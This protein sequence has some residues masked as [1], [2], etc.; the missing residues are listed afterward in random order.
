MCGAVTGR[1]DSGSCPYGGAT[2]PVRPR[3]GQC[4]L[5]GRRDRRT[6]FVV[7]R[8]G[9]PYV[10]G[11]CSERDAANVTLS[12]TCPYGRRIQVEYGCVGRDV[13]RGKQAV[14]GGKQ[15]SS[16]RGSAQTD[17]KMFEARHTMDAPTTMSADNGASEGGGGWFTPRNQPTAA[18][19]AEQETAEGS[20]LAA[21]RP[22]RR[23]RPGNSPRS[24][25]AIERELSEPTVAPPDT[26][27]GRD[28]MTPAEEMAAPGRRDTAPG[29]AG[30]DTHLGG[31]THP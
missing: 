8:P 20:R 14:C 5:R 28:E 22:V 13:E 7:V 27:A 1:V 18:P 23:P 9:H 21:L 31:D 25:T 6:A 2:T 12:P 17:R 24:S 26:E 19:R 4:S 30:G 29:T 3:A 16:D 15:A 11:R 10:V